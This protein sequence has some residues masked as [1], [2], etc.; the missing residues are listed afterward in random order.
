MSSIRTVTLAV[1]LFASGFGLVEAQEGDFSVR[2]TPTDGQCQVD[3]FAVGYIGYKDLECNCVFSLSRD[4]QRRY[5]FRAE[6][7]IGG[8]ES[9]S[10][11]DGK[12]R[13]GD[14]VA[15]VDG[16]L[17]TTREGGRRF[18]ELA[19]G[20]PVT[21]TVRRRGIDLDVTLVPENACLEIGAVPPPRAPSRTSSS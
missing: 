15:A 8:I 5:H 20:E 12:L 18:S 6:P 7:V 11:A 16:S 14:V 21:L 19:P 17:I 9:G 2:V 10:P 4:G 13:P 1:A 3:A